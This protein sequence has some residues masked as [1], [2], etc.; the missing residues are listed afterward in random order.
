MKNLFLSLLL[1]LPAQLFAQF[2]TAKMDSVLNQLDK[3]NKAMVSIAMTEKNAI[4]CEGFTG[5][6]DVEKNKKNNV[7][8]QFRIGS[9]SKLFTAVM[10]MQLVEE[11]KIKLDNK[12]SEYFGE[13]PNADKIT[14]EQLLSHRSGLANYTSQQDYTT[15][16][17]KPITHEELLK[18][19]AAL[20][21]DFAP[22]EKYEYSNTNYALLTLI[23]EKVTKKNYADILRQRVCAKANLSETRV[24]AQINSDANEAHSYDYELGKWVKSS[25]TDMSIPLGAGNIISTS[26]DLCKFI[27]ALFDLKLVSKASLENMMTMRDGYGLGM[28]RLPFG[29]MWH[30]GHTGGIDGFQS[31]LAYNPEQKHAFCILG[32]GYNYNMNDLAIAMLSIYHKVPY[33]VPNFDKKQ[34]ANTM[35][36]KPGLYKSSKMG[37]DIS[38]KEEDGKLSAQATGQSAF[39]LERV[40]D[41]KYKFDA[42]GIEIEFLTND[43]QI[44]HAFRLK[45]GG[46]EFVFEKE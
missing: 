34:S 27:E 14:I 7:Y 5:Y 4:I 9:I 41:M 32:N 15:Y 2:N 3:H 45:Q 23:I 26:V 43:K 19:L 13:M 20:K 22:G 31:L 28:I 6:A 30:Y 8:T 36:G 17:Q 16:N 39:P 21:P 24:G 29:K 40:S 25:E 38:I 1:S 46:M 35:D 37:M 12:L 11:K 18:K 33:T 10:L 42:A 44:I